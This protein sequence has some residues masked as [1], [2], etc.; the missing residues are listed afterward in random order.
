M[1]TRK[2]VRLVRSRNKTTADLKA[3]QETRKREETIKK[4]GRLI[5]GFLLKSEQL[6]PAYAEQTVDRARELLVAGDEAGTLPKQGAPA[7]M[8]VEEIIRRGKPAFNED[9]PFVESYEQ[10]LITWVPDADVTCQAL[11]R[12]SAQI[13]AYRAGRPITF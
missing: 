5:L 12:A 13:I 3:Q 10:W 9:V 2:L 4:T 6:G 1:S 11:N 7:G 8:R